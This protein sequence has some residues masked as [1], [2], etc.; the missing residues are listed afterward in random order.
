[1]AQL[2]LPVSPPTSHPA[3]NSDMLALPV[4]CLCS[5]KKLMP[6]AS[7]DSI[8]T[9]ICML[10]LFNVYHSRLGLVEPI[11]NRITANTAKGAIGHDGR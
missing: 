6:A 1:L 9:R 3:S 4:I 8:K 5:S 10:I 11:P 2:T 7:N